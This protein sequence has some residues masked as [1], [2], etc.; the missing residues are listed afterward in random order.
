M[1]FE[2]KIFKHLLPRARAWNM[3]ITKRLREFFE[4]LAG[5]PASFREYVD[6]IWMDMFPATT[7]ELT[8]WEAQYGLTDS[9]GLT[10]QQRRDR[11]AGAM[12][13]LGGLGPDYIQGVLQAA[14]FDV[15]IHEWWVPASDPAVA[16]NPFTYIT[17]TEIPLVN[18]VFT[19]ERNYTVLAGEPLAEAGEPTAEAGEF[20]GTLFLTKIYTPVDDPDLYPFYV[21]VGGEVFPNYAT[22]PA[23]R[24]DEFEDLLLKHLPTQL[25]IL[26]LITY[27]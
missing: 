8:T 27:T 25:W 12:A 5:L 17:T 10:E 24:R 13:A 2:L 6:L 4:G 21:Y 22:V 9:A 16:R 14:G 1:S 23:T 3:T 26:P 15:Y 18:K 11:L 7:R 20:D 19:A